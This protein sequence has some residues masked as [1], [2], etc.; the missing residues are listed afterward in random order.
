MLEADP[1]MVGGNS[2]TDDY[3]GY[4]FDIGHR[5]FSKNDEVTAL[6]REVLP[7]QLIAGDR[8][9]RIY[10]DRKFFD[11]PC[12]PSTPWPALAPSAPR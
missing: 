2:R 10:Y 6:W 5:F 9:S 3:K 4:H 7:G 8:M 11:Y 12:G 1:R